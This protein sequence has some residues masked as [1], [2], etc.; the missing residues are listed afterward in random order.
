MAE[1]GTV[2][3]TVI[4]SPHPFLHTPRIP[5]HG[6]SWQNAALLLEFCA[7]SLLYPCHITLNM[8]HTVSQCACYTS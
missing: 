2:S 6:A 4:F 8:R 1:H 5:L 7:S 3:S